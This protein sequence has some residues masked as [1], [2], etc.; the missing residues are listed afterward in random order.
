M[1]CSTQELYQKIYD[2]AALQ[3]KDTALDI[4]TGSGQAAAVLAQS[5]KQARLLLSTGARA[6]QVWSPG[7]CVC[8]SR[9]CS[10][11]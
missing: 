1:A 10:V 9:R 7:G 5:F 11:R 8:L 4:A 2:F 3:Y 6:L